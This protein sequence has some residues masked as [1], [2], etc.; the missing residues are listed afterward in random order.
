LR[1]RDQS[2]YNP[3]LT[4]VHARYRFIFRHLDA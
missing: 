1:D 2:R 3:G 4:F